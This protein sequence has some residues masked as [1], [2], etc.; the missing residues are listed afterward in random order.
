MISFPLLSIP[1][2]K[3][4]KPLQ[5]K[6][7]SLEW[8]IIWLTDTLQPGFLDSASTMTAGSIAQK[9]SSTVERLDETDQDR[10]RL[11]R[12]A[13]DFSDLVRKRNCLMHGNPHTAPSGEQ[14][15]LYNGINGYKDWTIDSMRDFSSRTADASI[16]AGELRNKRHL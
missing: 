3:S 12:L 6:S 14:R 16:K 1:H 2:P 10:I 15:L 7:H 4:E 9:F 8:S 11:A 13:C 5:R